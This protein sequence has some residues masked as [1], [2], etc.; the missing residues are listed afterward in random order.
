[1]PLRYTTPTTPVALVLSLTILLCPAARAKRHVLL[2]DA[3]NNP[4]V[5]VEPGS[6]FTI[7]SSDLKID[8]RN[9]RY[10]SASGYVKT[11][12]SGLGYYEA[13]NRESADLLVDISYGTE[14]PHIE[15]DVRSTIPSTPRIPEVLDPT[16]RY[17]NPHRPYRVGS[18]MGTLGGRN[19]GYMRIERTEEEIIPKTIYDKFLKITVSENQPLGSKEGRIEAWNV[20]VIY[21]NESTDIDKYLPLLAAAAIPYVGQRTQSQEKVV[22]R[23]RDES[24]LFVKRGM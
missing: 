20:K 14:D 21:Q 1:M 23:D 9:P 13:P 11:I 5:E 2:V 12:L 4:D 16:I 24:V 10:E 3:I 7:M 19:G 22:L 17:P 15:F 18:G 6:S 8:I